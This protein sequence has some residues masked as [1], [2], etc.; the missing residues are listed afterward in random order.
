MPDAHL[1]RSPPL[2]SDMYGELI[3]PAVQELVAYLESA[4]LDVDQAR[5]RLAH[6]IHKTDKILAHSSSVETRR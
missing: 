5:S 6:E 1:Q 3:P 2:K 4:G